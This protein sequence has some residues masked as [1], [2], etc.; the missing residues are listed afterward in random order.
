MCWRVQTEKQLTSDEQAFVVLCWL[1]MRI[2]RQDV[3]LSGLRF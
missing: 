1:K 2:L 3:S